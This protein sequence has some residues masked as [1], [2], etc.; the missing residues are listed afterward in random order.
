MQINNLIR[1]IFNLRTTKVLLI[2][3]PN[4]RILKILQFFKLHYFFLD[5][6]FMIHLFHFF[7]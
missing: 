5:K 3:K 7:I 1:R 4:I 2:K 6:T